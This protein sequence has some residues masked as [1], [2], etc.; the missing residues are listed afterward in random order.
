MLK[1]ETQCESQGRAPGN[2]VRPRSREAA[3]ENSNLCWWG[4]AGKPAAGSPKGE[5]SGSERGKCAIGNAK[6]APRNAD[7]P[8]GPSVLSHI[9]PWNPSA[10]GPALAR[11]QLRKK[12]LVHWAAFSFHRGQPSVL[13]YQSSVLGRS[14]AIRHRSPVK[15]KAYF[16]GPLSTIRHRRLRRLKP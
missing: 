12:T 6:S 13:R 16:T 1:A 15:G 4:P 10:R 7:V 3:K 9:A 5:M 11:H 8:V 2:A 14:A